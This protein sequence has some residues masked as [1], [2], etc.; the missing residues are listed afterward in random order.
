MLQDFTETFN[1]R[2]IWDFGQDF[3]SS[4]A[5]IMDLQAADEI[6]K[7]RMNLFVFRFL[8]QIEIM[9]HG[10]CTFLLSSSSS[11]IDS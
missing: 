8:V 10:V 5:C 9:T 3:Y 2:N 6:S 7:V 1:C 11:P 4:V